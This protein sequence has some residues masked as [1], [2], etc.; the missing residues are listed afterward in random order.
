LETNPLPADKNFVRWLRQALHHLYDPAELRKNPIFH[1]FGLEEQESPSAF[2]GALVSGI[3]TLKPARGS[4]TQ[5]EAWRI[6]EVLNRRYVDQFSQS[7][8]AGNLGLSDRQLRRYEQSA[9]QAL[10]DALW[11][12]AKIRSRFQELGLG[13]EEEGKPGS[14]SQEQELAWLEKSLPNEPVN[15]PS[16][17]A[18]LLKIVAP[19]LEARRIS[20]EVDFAEHFPLLR[21]QSTILRQ[22]LLNVLSAAVQSIADGCIRISGETHF[23]RVWVWVEPV[24]VLS[25]T[26]SL[27]AQAWNENL[28]M[29]RQLAAISGGAIELL[30]RQGEGGPQAIKLILPALEEVLVLVIDDNLDTLQLF[31]RYLAGTRYHFSAARDPEHA[32]E[33]ASRIAPQVIILDV[34]LP[35]IDG[36]EMLGRLRAHPKTQETPVIICT[37][38]P[39]A[40][41]AVTL[42]AAGFLRKPFN[43][44]E[45][46]AGLDRLTGRPGKGSG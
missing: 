35:G 29:A 18:D 42:G 4:S 44:Q 7:E 32:L 15:L 1:L 17:F 25:E 20:V 26:D 40:Q 16:T 45:L 33:L 12:Q 30:A 41:L 11:T 37:I 8:V 6:Y 24:G 19:L 10:A 14:S 3:E 22:A 39:Q 13:S 2:R 21:V 5:S 34:M 23:E 38:L 28:K 36:W 31:Q 46:V 27:G 9:L 43:R